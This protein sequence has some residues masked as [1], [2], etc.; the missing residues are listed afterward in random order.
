MTQHSAGEIVEEPR[1]SPAELRRIIGATMM[2]QVTEWYDYAVF[3][4]VAVQIGAT[5]FPD[6]SES[7]RLLSSLA[8]F[9]IAFMARPIGGMLIGRYGD[10]SGR[11]SVLVAS[12]VMMTVATTLMG[13]LPGADVI[14]L[15]APVLLVLARFI[16][17]ISAAG[18][19][20]SAITFVA[21][22][23]PMKRRGLLVALLF[24]GSAGGYLLANL[25]VLGLR[26]ALGT[27]AFDDWGWRLAFLFALPLGLTGLYIRRKLAESPVFESL[28]EEGAISDTPLRDTFTKGLG[29]T[30]QAIGI[31]AMSFVANY[32]LVAYMPIHLTQVGFAARDAAIIG[33]ISTATLVASYPFM[34]A[35]SD[36]V[37]RRAVMLGGAGF[38]ALF[39]WPL[40]ALTISGAF[41]PTLFAVVLLALPTAAFI[42]CLGLY[43]TEFI[44]K[45][46]LMTTFS[47]GF[48][49]SS[50]L[51][52]GTSLWAFGMLTQATG[53]ARM[54]GALM[55]ASAVLSFVTLLTIRPANP[56]GSGFS[57]RL[58]SSRPPSP[59]S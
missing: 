8:V 17:G 56:A 22:S 21:E 40:F 42:A 14:G 2:G 3:A 50:A 20:T 13:L 37:G 19:S 35:L 32:L 33:A 52:G 55:V 51:F 57:R 45:S 41:A 36:R 48:N 31:S 12:L 59:R 38:L 1:P 58:G 53:D 6:Q 4:L 11:R 54:P 30:M 9:G 10:R 34:G 46:R 25:V 5:F 24:S 44:D 7:T 49:I 43:C 39:G 29:Q 18:E 23:V 47:S 27:V 16:Q 15:A 26:E 28:M